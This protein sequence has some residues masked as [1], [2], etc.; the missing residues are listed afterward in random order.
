MNKKEPKS[1]CNFGTLLVPKRQ[2][3]DVDCPDDDSG[4]KGMDTVITR[5]MQ[6]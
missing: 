4:G 1:C 5:E 6:E 2:S 3:K